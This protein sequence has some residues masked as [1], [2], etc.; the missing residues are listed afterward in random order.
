[1]LQKAPN[2]TAT[3]DNAMISGVYFRI[4]DNGIAINP[5]V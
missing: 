1:M 2:T 3:V 5:P 4:A